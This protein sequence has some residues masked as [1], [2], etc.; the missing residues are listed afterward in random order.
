MGILNLFLSARRLMPYV[1]VNSRLHTLIFAGA[2]RLPSLQ[3]KSAH[4]KA[5]LHEIP[6]C[7]V[8]E[9]ETSSSTER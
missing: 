1:Q 7:P 2:R 9:W 3:S 8:K 5:L 4:Q 6:Y